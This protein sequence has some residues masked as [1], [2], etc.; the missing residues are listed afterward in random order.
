M[1]ERVL[2]VEDEKAWQENYERWLMDG[3]MGRGPVMNVEI[4][5]NSEAALERLRQKWYS[6]VIV[7]LVLRAQDDLDRGGNV[8]QD[9]LHSRPEGTKHIVIS[10]RAEKEDVR[11]AA[12]KFGANDVLF[13]WEFEDPQVFINAV[14]AAIESGK[15]ARPDFCAEA[16]AVL[17]GIDGKNILEDQIIYHLNT[18]G[19]SWHTAF[20]GWLLPK[21]APIVPH[22]VRTNLTIHA[23]SVS[24]IFWSRQ[25]GSAVSCS[26]S[27]VKFQSNK[28]QDEHANWLGF[29]PSTPL[30]TEEKA[31][32]RLLAWR[33]EELEVSQFDLR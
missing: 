5:T 9:F 21:F 1:D 16:N 33:H 32:L 29:D 20:K 23:G 14:L 7:D 17:L 31:S 15:K 6:V 30:Y 11:A 18:T 28:Q 2:I 26:I 8:V 25:L 3:G 12:F 13:K 24:G 19:D 27:N 4:V 22:V 10:A